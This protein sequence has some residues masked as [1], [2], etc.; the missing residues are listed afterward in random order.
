MEEWSIALKMPINWDLKLKFFVLPS[1]PTPSIIFRRKWFRAL[2]IGDRLI[3]VSV[4]IVDKEVRVRSIQVK[5]KEKRKIEELIFEYFGLGDPS[6]LYNFMRSDEK[7]SLLLKKFPNFGKGIR[8][9]IYVFEGIVKAIIQQQIAF[10]VA[11]NIAANLIEKYG[12]NIRFGGKRV[13]DFPTPSLLSRL[14]MEDLKG[15]GLS[16][17]KAEVIINVSKAALEYDLE[18][19]KRLKQNEVYEFLTSFK[20]IGRWT[21]ELVMSMSLGFNVI[22]LGDLG[23]RRVLTRLYPEYSNNL[24]ILAKKFGNFSNDILCYLF[25]EDRIGERT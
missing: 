18:N 23:V 17:R 13:F 24:E 8:M 15:C 2:K 14:S 4:E 12:E 3:P 1:R 5:K 7:L 10:K 9:S 20:G 25:L 16:K 6:S 22:P 11:E 21:A 19:L